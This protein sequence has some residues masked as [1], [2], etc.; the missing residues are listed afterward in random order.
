MKS[1]KAKLILFLG[2]LVVAICISLG[3][4]SFINSTKSLQS[5]LRKTL[6]KIAEQTASSVQGRVDGQLSELEAIAAMPEIKDIN[7]S[8]ENKSAILIEQAKRMGSIK[9]SIG[10]KNGDAK[11]TDGTTVNVKERDYYQKALSGKSNVS[12]PLIGKVWSYVK[13]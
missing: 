11:G 10:D 3:A 13:I 9:L 1:I 12:D 7:N 4:I 8:W 2:L 5:N 6:P